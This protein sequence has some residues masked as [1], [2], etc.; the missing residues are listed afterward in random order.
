MHASA[1]MSSSVEAFNGQIEK[2]AE[3]GLVLLIGAMLPQEPLL[4][5]ACWFVPLLLFVL[6]PASA[7]ISTAGEP[8]D[9][10]QRVLIAW[11]GI[12]GIGSVFYLLFSLRHGLAGSEG[13]AVASL[14]LST[15]AASI[16][17]HGVS[18][19]PLMR[20][21]FRRRPPQTAV[22]ESTER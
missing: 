14:T 6:R 18:A 13:Q 3:M 7:L 1:T 20:R 16:V 8:L 21:Y 12:R 15:V 9:R 4:L 10:P 2:I 19:Q 5:S 17:V 11:F 22:R